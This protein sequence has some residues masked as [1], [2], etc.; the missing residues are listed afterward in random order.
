MNS[1]TYNKGK[2]TFLLI[3]VLTL[4]TAYLAFFGLNVGPVSLKGASEMRFGIDIRGG[5]DVAFSPKDLGRLPTGD[6]LEAVR[7]VI[8]TRLDQNNILDRDVTLDKQN[9]YVFVRF[10]WK[11][12]ETDFDPAKA[13]AE[14]GSMAHLTFR[15][16]DG[17]V[18]LEG[19][20]VARSTTWERDPQSPNTYLVHLELDAVGSKSFSEAT[21]RL[22]GKNISI[23][24]D[25]TMISSPRVMSAITTSQCV[26]SD[27]A[28]A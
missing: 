18:V 24:M 10:P 25:E 26:I 22:V 19:K 6:E 3:L 11:T 20:N 21:A 9:G 27:I 23:Y 7:A 14:L 8:E 1:A 2:T 4:F 12:G 15:D 17:K 5:V 16:P 13:I 28:T